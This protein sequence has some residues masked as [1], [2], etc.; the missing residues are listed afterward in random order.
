MI[1]NTGARTDTVQYFSPWL[2]ERF[3]K[4]YVYTRNP[5]FPQKLTRFELKP[6]LVDCV[7]FCSKNY[8]PILNRLHEITNRF[9]TYFFYTITAYEKDIEPNVPN[10]DKSIDTLFKLEK[11]VG[12]QRICWRY[13]PVFV[14]KKYSI[15]QHL[16]TFEHMAVRLSSHIDR[17]VFSFVELYKKVKEN[18]PELEEIS[19]EDKEILAREMGKIARK[20]KITLQS[21]ATKENFEK[22]G[23]Q[24]SGCVTLDILSK[25]NNGINFKNLKH[26]GMRANCHCIVSH[27]IGAYNTCPNSCKYCYANQNPEL[28]LKNYNEC[29]NNISS[30][31]LLGNISE[32]DIISFAKQKLYQIKPDLQLELF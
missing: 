13:D 12:K 15:Q 20:Y 4:G 29:K 10:L 3:K 32:N 24:K 18:F 28:V 14:T 22:Y 30:P 19:K 26:S 27:D 17:C 21:C 6:D 25:A 9:N 16:I 2:L 7:I 23:I 8:E 11:I 5:M 1:I 31:I